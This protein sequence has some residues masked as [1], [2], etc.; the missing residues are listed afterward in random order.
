MIYNGIK[1]TLTD[2][3][4]KIILHSLQNFCQCNKNLTKQQTKTD[5]VDSKIVLKIV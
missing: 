3:F 1:N 4:I 2:L 5:K